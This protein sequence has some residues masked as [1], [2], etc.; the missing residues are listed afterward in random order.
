MMDAAAVARTQGRTEAV[1]H[2]AIFDANP[3]GSALGTRRNA[4]GVDL[5]RD[6]LLLATSEA[7]A[8]HQCVR[9]YRPHLIVDVHDYPARRRILL[10]NGWTIDPD[11]QLAV[12]TNP[13]I[14]TSLD[15]ADLDDLRDRLRRDLESRGFSFAPYTL[16]RRSGKA[17]PSTLNALDARNALSLRYGIPTLLL[18]GRDAGRRGTE[19]EAERTVA[20][21]Y[22]ALR[23]I[24]TWAM[25]HR[26]QL[27]RPPPRFGAGEVVPIDAYW[28]PAPSPQ[29]VALR[30]VASGQRE[31]VPWTPYDG[32]IRIRRTVRVPEAYAVRGDASA[33]REVLDRQGL[34]SEWLRS[35][36][37]ATVEAM[38]H[39]QSEPHPRSSEGVRSDWG[40][41]I[42]LR[43]CAIY[44][45]RQPGG[46]ALPLWL[47]AGSRFGL[48]RSGI[49]PMASLSGTAPA[50]LRVL[51]WAEATRRLPDR[52][53]KEP[54]TASRRPTRDVLALR[55]EV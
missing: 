20:A 18:E 50:V 25:G 37:F 35:P 17:R 36:R 4:Q 1:G 32:T 26:N 40:D 42:D 3:D 34:Q 55:G 16:F 28:G 8:I 43:G 31:V 23:S 41:A 15:P 38:G 9:R 5:N 10:A 21:Q 39:E 24:E 49:L 7:R 45:V 48:V 27:L 6:H 33:V 12:P 54:R 11:V 30:R 29:P 46:R 53:V 2:A 13:A 14:R 51:G 47:E 19:Q 22:E 52:K 44:P